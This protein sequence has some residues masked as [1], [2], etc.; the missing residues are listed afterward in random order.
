[1]IISTIENDLN[2]NS[3]VLQEHVDEGELVY[4]LKL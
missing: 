1:M 4:G 2:E 3:Y